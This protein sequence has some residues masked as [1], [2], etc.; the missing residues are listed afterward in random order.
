MQ[1]HIDH[2][3]AERKKNPKF[4][5]MGY[6]KNSTIGGV[7]MTKSDYCYLLKRLK[8]SR[9]KPHALSTAA[10]RGRRKKNKENVWKAAAKG[11]MVKK[12]EW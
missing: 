7:K 2:C 12:R 5:L 11:P 4:N 1:A 3:K 9:K 6:C 8:G 10:I